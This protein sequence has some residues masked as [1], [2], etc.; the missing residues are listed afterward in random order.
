[1]TRTPRGLRAGGR[2]LW[3][4]VTDGYELDESA[5]A[6]LVEACHTVDELAVLRA[7]LADVTPVIESAQGP[8]VHPLYAEIRARRLAL[9]KLVASVGLPKDFADEGAGNAG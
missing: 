1:M 5:S 8:R 7:A 3:Q 6:V 2:R 4:A 9:A